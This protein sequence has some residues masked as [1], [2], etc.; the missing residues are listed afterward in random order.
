MKRVVATGVFN[1]LH[2]GHI[3]YLGEAK[4]LGDELYVIVARDKTVKNKKRNRLIPEEQRLQVIKALKVVDQAIL[5]DEKDMFKP[6]LKIGP[7]IIAIGRDQE[8]D[9]DKLR[10]ELKRRGL[11]TEIVRIQKYLNSEFCSSRRIIDMLRN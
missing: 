8:F 3:L 6:I 4:K 11:E 9:E 5:G 2:P 7:D 1:I 10:G